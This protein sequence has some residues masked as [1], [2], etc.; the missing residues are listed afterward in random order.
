MNFLKN[1]PAASK[2]AIG[3]F[4]GAAL[5]GASVANANKSMCVGAAQCPAQTRGCSTYAQWGNQ[6]GGNPVVTQWEQPI[7]TH[8]PGLRETVQ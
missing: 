3:M 1:R 6:P 2:L 8:A 7:G 5:F 4:L